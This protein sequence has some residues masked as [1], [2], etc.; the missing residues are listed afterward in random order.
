MKRLDLNWKTAPERRPSPAEEA[1]WG[2]GVVKTDQF[3]HENGEVM[4]NIRAFSPP[5]RASSFQFE[6]KNKL[7]IQMWMEAKLMVYFSCV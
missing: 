6:G 2:E 4:K 5:P 3:W 7:F 1:G